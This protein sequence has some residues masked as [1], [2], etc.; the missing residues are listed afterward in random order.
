M[1]PLGTEEALR[2][3]AFARR[4]MLAFSVLTVLL[5]GGTTALSAL[6]MRVLLEHSRTQR[7]E[8]VAS[9]AARAAFV[10]L[11]LE[12]REELGRVAS[13]Y[14]G[15]EAL[16][17]L[18][19]LDDRGAEWARFSRAGASDAGITVTAPIVAPGARPADA[20]VGRVEVIMD[21]GDIRATLA[22]Q[23]AVIFGF[24]GLLAAAILLSG[25]FIIRRLTGGMHELAR[26][27][28]RAEDLS[29][30]NRELE[31][32]A[33]VA[34]HDLQAP[35]RRIAGFAQLVSKRYKG[36]LD[37][38]GDE[39]ISRITAST[40]RMQSLIQDL[41]T[42]SRAGSRELAPVPTDVNKLLRDVLADLDAQRKEAGAEIVVEPL[43]VVTA[44]PEQLARVL[45]N[46][47][48]NA[49]KFRGEKPPVVRVSARRAGDEW[50][51]AVADNGIG[52]D[53]PYLSEVFK[54]FRRLH[55]TTAFPGTGIGL[56]ICRKI[57][58]RHGGRIWVESEPGRGSTF[59]F[60]LG[61]SH[62]PAK[63]EKHDG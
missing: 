42:Y 59:Y 49:L 10:P 54:M 22:W 61:A 3:E 17:S 45:Q 60:T 14:E 18:R 57:V 52:I 21:S 9:A 12:D 15:Q 43:P 58:E 2:W 29:R 63:E 26:Q 20:P 11:S 23:V 24:N 4:L 6:R 16:A 47:I 50:T 44:D 51:F 41:L 34:S 39:F 33:Y 30:S 31:E 46:L 27:A 8:A 48:G 19:I 40:E 13:Y 55:S 36:K 62:A 1:S 53:K 28:A 56:A 25:M 37:P 5:G 7:G 38:E 35:L 32:F